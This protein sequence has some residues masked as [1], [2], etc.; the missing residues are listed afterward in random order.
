[1]ENIDL[2]LKNL[3]GKDETKAQEAANFLVDCSDISLFKKLVEKTDYLYEFVRNNV[4]HRIDNA[5]NNS[6]YKN[7][8]NFFSVYSSYYDDLFAFILAKH[9]DEELTD[10]IFDL[11]EKGT[12][13]QK[14]YAAKY[15]Y[16]IP[17]TIALDVLSKYA[18]SDDENLSYNS[19]ETLGQMQDDI[20]FDIALSL[21]QSNDDFEKLKAVKFFCAYGKNYP[22]HEIF[23]AMKTSGMPEN[24]A[25]QIPY[26]QSLTELL[27]DNQTKEDALLT[28]DYIISG[29]GEI[30][31]L[32]DIFQ[33]ELFDLTD[34]LININKQ[35]NVYSG[36]ISTTLLK[37]YAKFM[38][39]T[40]N[41]EYSFDET[42]EVKYEVNAIF[43]LLKNQ[44]E[45]FWKFQKK[46]VLS[47][48]DKDRARILAALCVI[49]EFN[50]TD[51]ADKIRNILISNNDEII[52]C[53][54]LSALKKINC[55]SDD[56]M[57]KVSCKIHNPNIKAIIENLA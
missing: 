56:D 30:L 41:Q 31:P 25:G 15:F 39:F 38:L 9:A 4:S 44:S 21:L 50:I 54:A 12:I 29:I 49:S 3:T 45:Q 35:E 2:Y 13:A 33:F 55:I 8:L 40:E 22:L 14:T 17:D 53:E 26:M 57:A 37:L 42:K 43:Q 20:S 11:L 28:I 6:N 34:Y 52:L 47:E 16:Y 36:R 51:S 32:S 18:F 5:V 1:M 46:Y 23:E 48:L 27:E 24:I 7:I 19:A 10:E